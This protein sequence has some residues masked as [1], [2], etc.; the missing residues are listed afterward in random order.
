MSIPVN[1]SLT[2]SL[3]IELSGQNDGNFYI[4]HKKCY[5]YCTLFAI[6]NSQHIFFVCMT[7]F[8]VEIIATGK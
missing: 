4:I 3:E 1:K 2:A 8:Q 7:I 6:N 5:K